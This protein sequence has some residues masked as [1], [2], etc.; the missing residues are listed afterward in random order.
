I[1][2][3]DPAWPGYCTAPCAPGRSAVTTPIPAARS[4]GCSAPQPG[5]AAKPDPQRGRRF[6]LEAKDTLLAARRQRE[7]GRARRLVVD[8]GPGRWPPDPQG[9]AVHFLFPEH[10]HLLVA[11]AAR[12]R[13]PAPGTDRRSRSKPGTAQP[14]GQWPA[15]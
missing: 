6:G 1:E 14:R 8:P 12:G 7:P 3:A 10:G 5:T 9:L 4:A 13:E 11:A 15:S 2:A